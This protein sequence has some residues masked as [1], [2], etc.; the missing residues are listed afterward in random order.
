MFTTESGVEH[1]NVVNIWQ[2]ETIYSIPAGNKILASFPF[3]EIFYGI[4]NNRVEYY[5]FIFNTTIQ[6]GCGTY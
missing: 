2:I 5:V 3:S 4:I 1:P 6:Y